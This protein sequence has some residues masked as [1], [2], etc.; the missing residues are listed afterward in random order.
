MIVPRKYGSISRSLQEMA[1]YTPYSVHLARGGEKRKKIKGNIAG[2]L[3]YQ[4][5]HDGIKQRQGRYGRIFEV[6]NLDLDFG[7]PGG[8]LDGDFD[9]VLF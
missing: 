3:T 7:F 2:D 9:F 8:S 1:F 6:S 5:V 4:D